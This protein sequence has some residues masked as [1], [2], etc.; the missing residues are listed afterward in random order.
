MYSIVPRAEAQAE[1]D[2]AFDWYEQQQSGLGVEFLTSIAEVLERI[3]SFPEAYEIVFEDV[4]RAIV[5]KLPYLIRHFTV[6]ATR[7]YIEFGSNIIQGRRCLQACDR[8]HF[9]SEIPM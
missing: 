1:F 2:L 3:Q 6:S 7:R 4:R 5:P 9:A 8:R